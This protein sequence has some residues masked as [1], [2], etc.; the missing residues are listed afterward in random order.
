MDSDT[1]YSFI[2]EFS[3]HISD[4]LCGEP[5]ASISVSNLEVIGGVS[6]SLSSYEGMAEQ[7]RDCYLNPE[8]ITGLDIKDEKIRDDEKEY[9]CTGKIHLTFSKTYCYDYGCY[10]HDMY[11][12][13][14]VETFKE[15]KIVEDYGSSWRSEDD[16]HWETKN[17]NC[18]IRM[19][20]VRNSDKLIMEIGY[21]GLGSRKLM[22][23]ERFTD[24]WFK[25][26][27][28]EKE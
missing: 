7:I 16:L 25:E 14:E 5:T 8:D 27:C 4:L 19:N 15:L 9:Q 2:A 12:S 22:S 17:G 3:L 21:Q 20:R 26:F 1:N 18:F 10:E 24:V 13:A 11:V 23:I 28:K 6:M